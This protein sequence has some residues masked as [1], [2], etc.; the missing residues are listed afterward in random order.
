MQAHDL[1]VRLEL[2]L[3]AAREAGQLAMNYYRRSNYQIELKHDASPV[4]RAD[5]EAEQLLR[6][7]IEARF[8]LDAILG[9][10][11]G[12]RDGTSGFRWILDPIDG[13]KAFICGV[14]LWGTLV[15]V[16]FE[17][18]S[19]L[20]VIYLPALDECVYAAE[21]TGAWYTVAGAP[22]QPARVSAKTRIS[23]GLF[24]TSEYATFVRTN[25]LPA[26]EQLNAAC[27]QARTWG[28][29][30]GYALVA[31]GRAE[32]MVDP[33][34]NVWD[35]AALQPILEAAGGTFTDWQ[36]Q[37]TIHGA[38]ALATNGHV[39][40]ETLAITRQFPRQA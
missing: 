40:E 21:G 3:S 2:A 20:G 6:A 32:I 9:E 33:K 28:D 26:Y 5:R 19:R 24:C 10:E 22:P 30:Y 11:F 16:E 34:M 4:T 15:G 23:D 13:T 12:S 37:R 17:T 18:H 27:W 36:G 35:C 31:T 38:E 1:A 8:P 25:R 7:R 39:L 29:C 14:P